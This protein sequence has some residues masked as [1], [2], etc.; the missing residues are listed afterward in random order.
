[1]NDFE[2]AK[3]EVKEEVVKTEVNMDT[4]YEKLLHLESVAR[5]NNHES[6][7]KLSLI[8]RCFSYS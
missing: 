6:K 7:E 5:K 4:L 8:L 2:K 1:M 3:R